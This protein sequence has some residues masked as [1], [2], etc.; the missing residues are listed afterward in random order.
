MKS[1]KH[2]VLWNDLRLFW[3][4]NARAVARHQ[5]PIVQLVAAT[6][7][8]PFYSKDKQGGW[9]KKRG[10]L[11]APN[12]IHECD[13]SDIPI[14]SV[15]IDPDSALGYW[16]S[17]HLLKD[18]PIIDFPIQ[19]NWKEFEEVLKDENWD[20]V[21]SKVENFFSYQKSDKL[22]EKDER[23]ERVLS[24]IAGHIDEP[25]NTATLSGIALLSESRLL[26][27]FKETM[28]LPIRNYILWFRLK[29]VLE[30]LLEGKSLTTAAHHAGFADQAHM[31]RTC[32][33]M[34][35]LPPSAFSKNSKF[36]QVS[37]PV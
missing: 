26:H 37:F 36:V 13:A 9:V 28:G 8:N 17:T 34:I 5:H 24:F 33:K 4:T 2:L 23:I 19:Y 31:T 25:I 32:V 14:L 15:D 3:G 10:L 20:T 16:V 6:S 1:M 18:Q 7:R 35:G 12:H 21:R 11:I 22:Q 27:L 30:Q 29:M